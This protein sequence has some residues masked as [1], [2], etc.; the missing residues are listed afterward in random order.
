MF[1]MEEET[2]QNFGLGIC[3]IQDAY[4]L[5]KGRCQ[6]GSQTYELK[7]S[8][9]DLNWRKESELCGVEGNL[10]FNIYFP[11]LLS[12]KTASQIINYIPQLPLWAGMAMLGPLKHNHG[13]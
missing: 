3:L 8:E 10:L 13:E 1:V 11:H 2:I 5:S 7:A 6:V 9:R 12:N 4:W